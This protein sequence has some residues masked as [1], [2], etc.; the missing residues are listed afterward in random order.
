MFIIS[1][2]SAINKSYVIDAL[3]D[4]DDVKIHQINSTNIKFDCKIKSYISDFVYIV[5]AKSLDL[6]EIINIFENKLKVIKKISENNYIWNCTNTTVFL[7]IN[8]IK[9]LNYNF[10]YLYDFVYQLNYDSTGK[11][12]IY[13]NH[14]ILLHKDNDKIYVVNNIVITHK[15]FIR[16]LLDIE[17]I[18]QDIDKILKDIK[19]TS[20]LTDTNNYVMEYIRLLL[21]NIILPQT[22]QN[23]QDNVKKQFEDWITKINNH[24]SIKDQAIKIIGNVCVIDNYKFNDIEQSKDPIYEL[25]GNNKVKGTIFVNKNGKEKLFNYVGYSK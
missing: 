21:L 23:F 20:D 7:N 8:N 17:F 6:T 12:N 22:Y 3:S 25:T 15:N 24:K 5:Y 2:M 14:L 9:K 19:T 16:K 18:K 11:K 1:P 4:I 13:N 10:Q